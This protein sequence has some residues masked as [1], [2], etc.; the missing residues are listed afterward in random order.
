VTKDLSG[1]IFPSVVDT[2]ENVDLNRGSC[3]DVAGRERVP[4]T[5]ATRGRTA[6][7]LIFGQS[8][9]ANSGDTLYVPRRRVFNFNLFDGHCYVARDPLL[10]ATE[11]R[12]NFAGRMADMLI[13]RGH[14][15]SVV[16][17]PIGVG[18]SRIEEWTTGG[19]RH[20]RLQLLIRRAIDAGLTFTHALWHQGES[21]ARYDPDGPLYAACF[22]NIHAALRRYGVDAPIY[23]AQATICNSPRN[24]AIRAAQRSLVDPRLGILPGPDTDTIGREHRYD[25]CHMGESGLI[26]H[27]ELW[28]EA[29]IEQRRQ[30]DVRRAGPSC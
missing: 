12:G 18:G 16:L 5:D 6:V 4:V 14:F 1:T 30:T 2:Y 22:M 29:L 17:A 10:G 21:N 24:K 9:G 20:R 28:V 27:A 3:N 26:R 23:V 13:E 15:D 7:M 8:N 19:S 25:G 11:N